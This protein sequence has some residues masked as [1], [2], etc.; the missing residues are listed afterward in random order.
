MKKVALFF[1]YIFI[2][3]FFVI[4]FLPKISL[5]YKAEELLH[6]KQIVFMG[7]SLS[8]NGI[9]FSLKEARLY[10]DDLYVANF[11][12]ISITTLLLYNKLHVDAFTLSSEMKQFLPQEVEYLDVS[13]SV[14]DPLHV[15]I[16][17]SGEFG[18][19]EGSV[20]VRDRNGSLHLLPS[21]QLS[22]QKPFWLRKLKKV[23]GEYIYA[24]RY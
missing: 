11:S 24:I 21:P 2:T 7:E 10:Y 19:L 15:N 8:D 9:S 4:V 1:T 20:N 16:S 13:Y 22:K 12:E 3:V 14:I 17:A 18:E 6:S 23:E 5:Y